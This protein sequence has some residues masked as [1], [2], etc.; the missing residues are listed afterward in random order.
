MVSEVDGEIV[1]R[2]VKCT[3]KWT[4][5]NTRN[6][7]KSILDYAVTNKSVYDDIKYMK[8]DEEGLYRL[9]KYRKNEI[10][11]TDH[12]TVIIVI[13]DS[14]VQKRK[15]MKGNGILTKKMGGKNTKE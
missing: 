15:K 1:N 14:I 2:T 12:N 11:E 4:R 5:K 3:G 10:K 8:I 13:D 6:E 7:E 9:S